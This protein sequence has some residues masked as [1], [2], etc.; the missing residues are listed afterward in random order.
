MFLDLINFQTVEGDL[1]LF[2]GYE[3]FLKECK[4]YRKISWYLGEKGNI[5]IYLL[6]ILELFLR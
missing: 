2:T 1:L 5:D 6:T 4:R 3:N